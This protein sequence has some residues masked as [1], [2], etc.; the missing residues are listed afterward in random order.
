MSDR[1][2]NYGVDNEGAGIR[3]TA[4]WPDEDYLTTKPLPASRDDPHGSLGRFAVGLEERFPELSAKSLRPHRVIGA[5]AI[6]IVVL[7]AALALSPPIVVPL[8][9][10]AI[11]LPFVCI[12]LLRCAALVELGRRGA[13]TGVAGSGQ[14]Q[15]AADP[16]E[17]LPRYAILVPLYNEAAV[18]CQLLEALGR[19]DYPKRRLQ[20]S[21]IVEYDDVETRNAIASSGLAENMR[22]VV[23]PP[24]APRTKPRALNFALADAVGEYVVVYDAEDLPEPDQLKRAIEV[25]KAGPPQIGCVQARLDLYNSDR[26]FFTRQFTIE[27]NALFDAILPA[28]ERLGLPIPLGGT[29]NH[30][31]REVLDRVGGWDAYNVTE[32]ADLGIRLARLGYSVKTLQSTTWEEAPESFAVWKGQRTRWLK[33]WMQTYLVLMRNP[34]GLWRD[35]GGYR[36]LGIQVLMGGM[37]FSALVHPWFYIALLVLV[38]S[39]GGVPDAAALFGSGWLM[40]LGLFNLV[41]GYVSAMALGAVAVSSRNRLNLAP[42]VIVM[43]VYWLMISFA[44]Y[45]ALWQLAVAPFFWE[46]TPHAGQRRS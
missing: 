27:Y 32:D 15:P 46:K 12:A 23:V 2:E 4:E 19:L 39:H 34:L 10:A 18:V 35:L 26:N 30:F 36:F 25:F 16:I 45:R 11:G 44:A 14:Q 21:L 28:L 24:G 20:I 43:P 31:P 1:G 37:I 29:S 13:F 40:P 5:G 3:S 38:I 33:G 17:G 42:G 9:F 8:L 7:C 6:A 41:A 22:V